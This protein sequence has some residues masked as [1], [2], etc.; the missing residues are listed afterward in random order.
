M[1]SGSVVIPASSSSE[2]IPVTV[3]DND[4]IDG[5]RTVILTITN[6]EATINGQV[7]AI[8]VDGAVDE[9]TVQ[10]ADD[11]AAKAELSVAATK[12][13]AAEP[14]TDGEFTISLP[15]GMTA[16][17]PIEVTYAMTGTAAN[18]T[19]YTT[20]SGTATIP[21][22][23]SSVIVAVDV[24]DNTIID[25]N[26]TVIMTISN[27]TV[28]VGGTPYS[29]TAAGTPATVTIADNDN[30]ATNLQLSIV[31]QKDGAEPATSGEFYISLPAGVTSAR[32]IT[33]NF[34]I[35]G[36]STATAGADYSAISVPVTIPAYQPGVT[37]PVNVLDDQIIESTETV[38]MNLTGGSDG[39]F[40]YTAGT[41]NTATV[42]ITDDD[43]GTNARV[44]LL[45]KVSDAV[46]GAARGRYRL[47]LPAGYT[48]SANI[49]VTFNMSGAAI[50]NTTT[51]YLLKQG[52]TTV[53]GNTVT[54]PAG[55]NEIWI[56]VEAYNDGIIEGPEG[57]VMTLTNVSS[58]VPFTID[59]ANT[60]ATVN[61]VDVNAPADN[62]V[63]I[64]RVNDDQ[65][66]PPMVS[67]V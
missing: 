43:A 1:L 50:R 13:S 54:I 45:T 35:D 44:V 2:V 62:P 34:T 41:T 32:D 4:I 66:H 36:G 29:L 30:T 47:G 40:T 37:V 20:L 39:Q 17:E 31:K 26:R 55:S 9:A 33:V 11:D 42:P 5:N 49:T 63:S 53:S 6:G 16:T 8:G 48:S 65:N 10:I 21:A 19:A 56:D 58:T 59:P 46:E 38:I 61:I 27:G 14:G 57:A 60:T 24:I 25:G 3:I 67:S 28:T 18:G 22:G 64:A 51:D 52:S 23:S 12:A 15:A 7:V